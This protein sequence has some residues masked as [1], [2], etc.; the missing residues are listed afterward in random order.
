MLIADVE[1]AVSIDPCDCNLLDESVDRFGTGEQP[2][3][4]V[5]RSTELGQLGP[6]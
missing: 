4:G 2:V 6:N 1:F 5:K 3:G